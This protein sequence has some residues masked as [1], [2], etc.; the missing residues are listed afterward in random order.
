MELFCTFVEN[1]AGSDEGDGVW[2]FTTELDH[3]LILKQSD[4]CVAAIGGGNRDECP[5]EL[6]VGLGNTEPSKFVD[7]MQFSAFVEHL[8]EGQVAE[9]MGATTADE[10]PANEQQEWQRDSG[11]QWQTYDDGRASGSGGGG[12]VWQWQACAD[13]DD[14]ASG[15]GGDKTGRNVGRDDK[16]TGRDVGK[17]RGGWQPRTCE[18]L[19]AFGRKN[20]KHCE[21]MVDEYSGTVLGENSGLWAHRFNT[22]TQAYGEENYNMVQRLAAEYKILTSGRGSV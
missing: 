5:M 10:E 8:Y 13:D 16:D 22:I 3:E 2:V 18:F 12:G 20:W 21:L 1:F 4:Q 14:M 7:I 11:W 6:I 9:N 17:R 19:H 15:F